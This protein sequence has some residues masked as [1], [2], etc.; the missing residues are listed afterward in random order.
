MV[1]DFTEILRPW[2]LGLIEEC[3]DYI[4]Q[5]E[6]WVVTLNRIREQYPD[7]WKIV[8]ACREII[9]NEQKNI[10]GEMNEIKERTALTRRST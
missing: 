4:K 3:K 2:N 10:Q 8:E 1:E 7:N 9:W 6:D 5:S